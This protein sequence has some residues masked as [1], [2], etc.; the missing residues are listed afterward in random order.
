[1]KKTIRIRT[2]AK[3]SNDGKR[4]RVRASVS[5]GHSTKTVSKT[6]RVK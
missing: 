3:P 4:I 5:T 2:T 6:Y 1:M